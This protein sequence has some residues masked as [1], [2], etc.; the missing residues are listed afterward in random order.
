MKAHCYVVDI[1]ELIMSGYVAESITTDAGRFGQ[2]VSGK[3]GGDSYTISILQA[4]ALGEVCAQ[5]RYTWK[6]LNNG[7]INTY[8]SSAV[9][10][11]R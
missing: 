1:G 10:R 2:L 7:C 11:S 3:T 9:T 5:A 6:Q 8:L 4:Q